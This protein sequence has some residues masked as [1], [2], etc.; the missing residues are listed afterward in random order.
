[1]RQ[2]RNEKFTS[3]KPRRPVWLLLLPILC[4]LLIVCLFTAIHPLLLQ[5]RANLVDPAKPAQAAESAVP[6]VTA[7][8]LAP[9]YLQAAS[10]N[11]DLLI[12]VTDEN[13]KE[14][15]DIVFPLSVE[16]PHGVGFG[17]E[18][19]TDGMLYLKGLEP[20]EYKLRMDGTEGYA[21]AAPISVTV[22]APSVL[23]GE[24][25]ADGWR[26][27]NGKTYYYG[28]TRRAYTGLRTVAGKEYYFNLYGEKADTLGIDVSF[29][30]KGINWPLVRQ[31]GIDF[32]IIRLG[33]RGWE[34][35]VL[36]E[37]NCFRQNLY[38]AK[39]A[40]L[41]IGVYIYSTAVNATEAASE[42]SMVISQ[43]GGMALDL[44]VFLDIEQ[45][46]DYPDGRADKLSK[47]R[48]AEIVNAFCHVIE[49]HGYEAGI[50][51]GQNYFKRHIYYGALTEYMTWLASY[52]TE[53]KLP[54]F[55]Y[56]YD[57]WQFTD[58]GIVSGIHGIVDMNAVF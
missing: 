51:S 21:A 11:R 32:A 10:T 4:I 37:D 13:G 35:G 28:R 39:A 26:S 30:N 27:E 33:Y 54:D 17:L 58:S 18:S 14:I 48:R 53:N 3:K 42:A 6:E 29:Y 46:G 19:G 52:T 34:T 44:P 57:M 2:K 47:V 1:M 55:P 43:L 56:H 31:Q 7:A 49:E 24:H 45:S 38:G 9:V 36:H 40:G 8:D 20:G 41:K 5:S 12:R 25:V 16:Y 15:P 23:Y 22:T 50:Y